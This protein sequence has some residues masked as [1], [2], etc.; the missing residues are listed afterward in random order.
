MPIREKNGKWYWG[1]R[2]PFLSREKAEL[3]EKAAYANGYRGDDADPDY[4]ENLI[5]QIMGLSDEELGKMADFC[6]HESI[7][8]D[9][10]SVRSMDKDGRLHVRMTPIS[11][12]TINE[13]YGS[14]IV[15]GKKIGLESNKKYKLLRDPSE[16]EKSSHT[17]NNIPLLKMHAPADAKN[18][19][20]SMIIGTLGSDANYKDD[21]LRNSLAVWDED[22][23]NKILNNEQSELSC[24]YFYTPDMAPG[25]W[26]GE[27]YDGVMRDIVGSH[28]ALVEK[29]RAGHDV[30]VADSK[31]RKD[32][33]LMK[34]YDDIKKHLEGKL[35]DSEMEKLID[36]VKHGF[37]ENN[38]AHGELEKG[39]AELKKE[40]KVIEKEEKS[41]DS[42][43]DLKVPAFDQDITKEKSSDNEDDKKK[44]KSEDNKE[45]D[46]D[47]KSA[48]K[49]AM[50]AAIADSAKQHLLNVQRTM[51]EI[52]EAKNFVNSIVPSLR[53]NDGI[54]ESAKEVYA[55]CAK[56]IGMTLSDNLTIAD[57]RAILSGYEAG[58]ANTSFVIRANDSK[59]NESSLAAKYPHVANIKTIR[60]K[61]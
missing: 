39:Q 2:G 12:A 24:S 1:S 5:M 47:K 16:L 56:A 52:A 29:G 42:V 46:K 33:E 60:G 57:Y 61:N 8:F 10:Q 55:E 37:E 19:M 53:A 41:N 20:K 48:D 18:P 38:K 30:R 21:Y 9:S 25:N 49:R 54:Y 40:H 4:G 3:V 26:N 7:A 32:G 44:D 36:I 22:Y 15:G 27:P 13:Y 51:K 28:V 6:A 31:N 45:D 50:D 34:I 35:D 11:K 23:I 59:P 14:E 58:N 17:F 43:E